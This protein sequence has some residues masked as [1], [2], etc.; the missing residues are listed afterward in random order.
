MVVQLK[1]TV[2]MWIFCKQGFV[3]IVQHRHLPG[4][5]LVRAR[6]RPDL[7]NFVRV[8]D[9]IS[10]KEHSIQ[11]TPRADYRFRTVACKRT[12]ARAMARIAVDIDYPNFKDAAHG[13]R[14]R[15]S[16]YIRVWR[17]MADFQA[18]KEEGDRPGPLEWPQ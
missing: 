15:D 6:A 17:A 16:A 10:G 5:L 9:E 3:S 4:K 12:V 7:E 14:V 8:L 18:D 13:D 1:G 11:E 2:F